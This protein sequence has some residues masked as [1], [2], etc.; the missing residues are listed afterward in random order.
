MTGEMVVANAAPP[1]IRLEFLKKARRLIASA[2][3]RDLSLE[4]VVFALA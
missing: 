2:T 3:L 1:A 4:D